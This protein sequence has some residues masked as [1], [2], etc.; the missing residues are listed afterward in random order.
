MKSLKQIYKI[1]API[2]LVWKALTDQKLIKSWSGSN[3]K[4]SDKHEK[5][6]LWDDQIYGKNIE[7]IKEKKLVQEW[8]S[9]GFE[10]ASMVTF[11]LK[12]DKNKTIV[13]LNHKNIPDNEF[14]GIEEGW[15]VYYMNPL[16]KLVES[17]V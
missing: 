10:E 5:F 6:S 16:K 13:T 11:E 1:N 14:K 9:S 8:F 4:M 17:L 2:E 3:A 12:Q 7:I 15:K